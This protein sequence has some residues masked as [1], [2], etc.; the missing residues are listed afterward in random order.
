[1]L[2]IGAFPSVLLLRLL[3]PWVVIRL[4]EMIPERIGHFYAIE[5]YLSEQEKNSTRQ[6]Q[7]TF[8]MVVLISGVYVIYNY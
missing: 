5:I 8:F 2:I 3:K 1:M 7:S 6:K 4:G